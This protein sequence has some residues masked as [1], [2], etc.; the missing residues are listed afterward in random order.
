MKRSLPRLILAATRYGALSREDAEDVAIEAIEKTMIRL[1]KISFKGGA[2]G[3]DPL[4]N[5]MLRAARNGLADIHRSRVREREV[6]KDLGANLVAGRPVTRPRFVS[7][8]PDDDDDQRDLVEPR[9]PS[10]GSVEG[11]SGE[12]AA[13]REFLETLSEQDRLMLLLHAEGVMNSKQIGEEVG[14]TDAAVRQQIRRLLDRF[15]KERA[16]V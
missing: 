16:N 5:Y 1:P 2:A 15:Q 6:R 10:D 8:G 13:M 7:D 9:A 11:A 12:L 4:F 14:R 3:K